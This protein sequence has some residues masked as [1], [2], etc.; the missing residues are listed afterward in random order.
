MNIRWFIGL[1]IGPNGITRY[2]ADATGKL[3][4]TTRPIGSDAIRRKS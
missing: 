3:V 4:P 2:V 1:A